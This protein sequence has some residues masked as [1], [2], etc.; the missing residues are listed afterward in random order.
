[1]THGTDNTMRPGHEPKPYR[2]FPHS[3]IDW[4]PENAEKAARTEG[5]TLTEDHWEVVRGLQELFARAARNRFCAPATCTMRSMSTSIT[6][7]ES[8]ISTSYFP[9]GQWPRAADSLA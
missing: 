4:S 9:R 8:S 7:A 6:K 5:L 2:K 1:M 3:P